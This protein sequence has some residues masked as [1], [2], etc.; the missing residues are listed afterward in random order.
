MSE[1]TTESLP[2]E[3]LDS[4]E[5]V[6]WFS[7]DQA[8]VTLEFTVAGQ[9]A[10]ITLLPMDGGDLERYGIAGAKT[11]MV[12]GED[13]KRRLEMESFDPAAKDMFLVSRTLRSWSLPQ[14][15]KGKWQRSGAPENDRQRQEFIE[16]NFRCTPKVWRWLV[17]QCLQVNGLTEEQQGN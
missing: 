3:V 12:Q 10:S 11:R 17:A 1:P 6:E 15:V 13:G 5:F 16:K 8:E 7:A 9:P 2:P 14:R 4:P